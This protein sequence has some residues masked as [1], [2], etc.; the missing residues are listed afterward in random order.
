MFKSFVGRRGRV[1]FLGG[2]GD[3]RK[4]DTHEVDSLEGE[5]E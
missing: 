5:I 1:L 3:S 4:N 2:D